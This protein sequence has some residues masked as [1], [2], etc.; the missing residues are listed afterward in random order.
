MLSQLG[1]QGQSFKRLVVP[2]CVALTFGLIGLVLLATSH[3]VNPTASKEAESGIVNGCAGPVTD[4]T[5]SGG[6]AVK[7]GTCTANGFVH[8]G[9]LLDRGE[10]NFVKSKIAA[11]IAPWSTAYNTMLNS[12]TG[13]GGRYAS[14]SYT[15]MPVTEV[16]CTAHNS[17]PSLDIGCNELL[18]DSIAAYTDS[19]IWYYT[20]NTARMV[21]AYEFNARYFAQQLSTGSV[22]SWLCGGTLNTG[23]LG[24]ELG[25]E[26][27]YNALH[28][29]LGFAMPYTQAFLNG[30]TRPGTYK[31]GLFMVSEELTNRDN[32]AQ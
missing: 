10:L 23:G 12:G 22:P 32:T 15:P 9:V 13:T 18:S 14:L 11:N 20:G 4:S 7:F 2:L 3:A 24:Y 29:R 19:L 1:I 28:D 6:S 27:A 26:V 8:P 21:A 30:Y 31:A 5:A 17:N 16:K 25:W